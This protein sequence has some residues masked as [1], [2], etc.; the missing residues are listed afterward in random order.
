M[1]LQQQTTA[2]IDLCETCLTRF[3]TMCEMDQSPDFFEDVKP[4]ADYWQ[5][6][7]DAWADEAVA[8]LTAHPQKYV[9]AVQIASAR[10]QLNQVIVQSFYKETSKKRFTDTVIAARYTLN[11]FRKHL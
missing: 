11:N 1:Q 6:K 5:P 10:E 4:Y 9:H 3:T 7:V 8:W 2:L